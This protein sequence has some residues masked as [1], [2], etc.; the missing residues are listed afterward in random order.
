MNAERGSSKS[1]DAFLAVA[2]E[3]GLLVLV[4][5]TTLAYSIQFSDYKV[6]KVGG[7]YL[8]VPLLLG[9]WLARSVVRGR[10]SLEHSPLYWPLLVYMTVSALALF[11]SSNPGRG[12]EVLLFQACLFG[13]CIVLAD[14]F[15]DL[16][17]AIKFLR[18]VVIIGFIVALIG[19]LQYGGV[20]LFPEITNFGD[21]PIS[22]LGN[23][24]LV[25][26]YLGIILP[27]TGVMFFLL[28]GL[29]DRVLLG[30]TL[31]L[32]GFLLLL[33]QSR[34][35]WLAVG[36]AFLFGLY[37][38]RAPTRWVRLAVVWVVVLA[39]LSPSLGLIGDQIY[40][41]GEGRFSERA[42][43][44]VQEVWERLRSGFDLRD[45]SISQRFIIWAD[46]LSLIYANPLLGVG[47]G[48]YEMAL[49]PHRTSLRH[50]DWGELVGERENIARHAHNEYLEIWSESGFVGLVA[51]LWMLGSL[52]GLGWRRLRRGG[53]PE[54]SLL[55]LGCMGGLV[56]TLVHS[57]FSFN[58]RDPTA[59]THFWIVAGLLIALCGVGRRPGKYVLDVMLQGLWRRLLAG[60]IGFGAVLL[61]CYAGMGYL[62]GDY[63]YFQGLKI[64]HLDAKS[65]RVVESLGRAIGWRDHDFRYHYLLGLSH[66][67]SGRYEAAEASLRRSLELHP[68]Y[69]LSLK[70]LGR[71]LY[72]LNRED[73]AIGVLKRAL[74]LDP[75]GEDGHALIALNYRRQGDHERAIEAWIQALAL[76][77]NNVRFI[78]SLGVEYQ[79]AGSLDL[80]MGVL[81]QGVQQHPENGMIRGHLGEVY[82]AAGALDKAERSL[83]KAIELRS[84]KSS[85]RSSLV[86]VYFRQK[87]LDKAILQAEIASRDDPENQVLTRLVQDLK[88]LPGAGE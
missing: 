65:D 52:L 72:Y 37:V 79:R 23:P 35:G 13:L 19:L 36:V 77:P 82:L 27:L 80:A 21:Q 45:F 38:R 22:T 32:T 69:A 10:F 9:L 34:A 42:E 8:V 55:A 78:N 88:K 60:L 51:L 6:P 57:F 30:F 53:D 16:A 81:E 47:P 40:L 59:A 74:K 87:E 76:Q 58:L 50:Q 84:E 54:I 63:Y 56:A 41:G 3:G 17:G 43:H 67:E 68:H 62:L 24:N 1:I 39:L 28:R 70:L 18:F 64:Y 86:Q 46:T 7:V 66:I 73:E 61:G 44:L 4:V 49:P 85:W 15:R 2:L 14:H 75:Q 71:T 29:K 12:V 25:A 26:H 83:L 20:L 33:T 5:L 31:G 11:F 48:N